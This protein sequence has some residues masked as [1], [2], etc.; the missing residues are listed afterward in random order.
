MAA[1]SAADLPRDIGDPLKARSLD[2]LD[3][4]QRVAAELP[5]DEL[6]GREAESAGQSGHSSWIVRFVFMV[7][8]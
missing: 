8:I 7:I 5:D 3:G 2:P 6:L 4:L 1:K